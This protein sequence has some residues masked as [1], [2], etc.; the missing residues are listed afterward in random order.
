MIARIIIGLIACGIGF[1]FVRKPD[2][3]LEFIGYI[4]F[5]EKAMMGGS[6]TFYKLLG[7]VI[8]LIGFLI[9]TNLYSDLMNWMVGSVVK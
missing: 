7:I 3:A 8:I 1:I 9:I 6:R 2:W 4:D 5:A